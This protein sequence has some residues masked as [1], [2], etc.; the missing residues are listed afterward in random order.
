LGAGWHPGNKQHQLQGRVIAFTILQALKEALYVWN[1]AKDYEL[2]DSQWHMTSHYNDVQRKVL[3]HVNEGECNLYEKHGIAGMCKFPMKARTEFTPRAYPSFSSIRSLMPP[4]M[5]QYI[6]PAPEN[7]YNP[8]DVFIPSLHPPMGA[9]DVLSIVEAG[10]VFQPVLV[11]DYATEFYKKPKFDKP[12]QVQVGKG[13]FLDTAAGDEYCD[14]TVDS[15]C[16][17]GEDQNCMLRSHNDGRHGLKFDGYSGWVVMNLPDVRNGFVMVKVQTWHPEGDAPTTMGWTS[18][19]NEGEE[20]RR[21]LGHSLSIRNSTMPTT[22]GIQTI[23]NLKKKKKDVPFCPEFQLEYAIDGKVSFWN[24]TTFNTLK[25]QGAI[26]RVVE[27]FVLLNDR[28]YTGGEEKEVEV[29]I[30]ITGCGR[31]KTFNLN[32]IYWS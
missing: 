6:N 14:G 16:E 5:Q 8:P 11:P 32:H 24:V 13:H 12:P 31:M 2:L 28:D 27:V 25:A 26:Q 22:D 1:E 10:P 3:E 4:E 7:M 15:W 20:P 19:N 9:I 18:I 17:R 21:R 29:A 30:R 23:R